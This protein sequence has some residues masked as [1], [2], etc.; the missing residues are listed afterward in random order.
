MLK[1]DSL[2]V[3]VLATT[4]PRW[5]GDD[6]PKFVY[7]LC[8]ELEESGLNITVLA[9]SHPDAEV[10]Q[11]MSGVK[12]YRYPYFFPEGFQRV[13]Y[14]GGIIE[15]V[16]RSPL[17]L[18]QAPLLVA[19]LLIHSIWL[20]KKENI[21]VVNS[22]WL[23]PNGLIGSILNSLFDIPHVMTLHAGGVLGLRNAPLH[24]IVATFTYERS[25][26]I[27]PV[28]THI[29]DEFIEM[30]SLDVLPTNETFQVQ[31]MGAHIDEFNTSKKSALKADRDLED[32]VMGLYVGRLAEKKGV[33]YLLDAIEEV[34][35]E[36]E[37]FHFTIVGTGTH[38]EEFRT[39]AEELDLDSHVKFTGWVSEEELYDYYVLSDFV[40]VPSIMTESGDTEGMPTVIS[41]A[42]SSGTP[43]IATNVGGISDV[44]KHYENGILIQEKSS[45]ELARKISLLTEDTDL[46]EELAEG[47]LQTA[48]QLSWK[49]C[50]ELYKMIL[51]KSAN[52]WENE[53]EPNES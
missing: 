32:T 39:Y 50:G 44:V 43:V 25:T 46:R 9:P 40:V 45:N 33:T 49:H 20:I 16:K 28:S 48:E 53:N 1:N 3:L 14:Q 2:S 12:V 24:S 4:F 30:L 29:R 23:V 41:E 22:H 13:A 21:D 15:A 51:L 52:V 47:A 8:K 7:E 42:F 35:E 11:T 19:S 38:E 26:T 17:S 34:C 37:D 10:S 36:R 31:P 18:L 6:C 27:A 5:E